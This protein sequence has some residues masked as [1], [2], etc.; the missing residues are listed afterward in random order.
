MLSPLTLPTHL[1]PLSKSGHELD[2][3]SPLEAQE[4]YADTALMTLLD[5][6]C[7]SRLAPAV[8]V[9]PN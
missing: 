2:V 7:D 6:Q 5:Q 8:A 4:T 9:D 1:P 3:P